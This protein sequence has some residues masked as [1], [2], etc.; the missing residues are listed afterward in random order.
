ML[1]G[2]YR[3]ALYTA[4]AFSKMGQ[5]RPLE[6]RSV[7]SVQRVLDRRKREPSVLDL[8]RQDRFWFTRQRPAYLSAESR[9]AVD[10]RGYEG[11]RHIISLIRQVTRI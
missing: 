2:G 1:K 7:S 4:N 3:C 5:V 11:L 9:P 10:T 6:E 8:I